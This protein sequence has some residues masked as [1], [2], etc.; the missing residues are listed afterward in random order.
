MRN[1]RV[2]L[3]AVCLT[4]ITALTACGSGESDSESYLTL[5]GRVT[6]TTPLTQS[7][8][9]GVWSVTDNSDYTTMGAMLS[10]NGVLT[11]RLG[12]TDEAG[13]PAPAGVAKW[14]LVHNVLIIKWPEQFGQDECIRVNDDLL[15]LSC[16]TIG[17]AA[18]GAVADYDLVPVDLAAEL[19]GTDWYSYNDDVGVS[20]STNGRYDAFS[21]EGE[22]SGRWRVQGLRL[23]LSDLAAC[24]FAGGWT[25]PESIMLLACRFDGQ[26]GE[27]MTAWWR[28]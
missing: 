13:V 15:S 26:P 12:L 7:D 5:S 11:Y 27:F 6:A 23:T 3:R 2:W 9:L 19:P 20:F 17:G 14:R 21:F 4:C 25:E 18:D 16:M 28:Y 24:D 8:V 22:A 1:F 10:R